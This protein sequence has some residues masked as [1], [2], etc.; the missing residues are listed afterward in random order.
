MGFIDFLLGTTPEKP[1]VEAKASMAI[2]YYQDTFSAFQFFGINRNDA[3]QV[4]AVARARNIIAGTIAELGLESYNKTTGAKVQG[5]SLLRQPDPALPR[6]VTMCWTV[7][8]ILFKGHAFWLVLAIDAQTGAATQARRID[9]TRVTFTTDLETDEIVNGFYLDGNLLPFTGVGSLIMFSGI[10]EGLLNRGGRTI[11]TALKLEEAVQRM[12]TEPNPT[13]VIKN[14]GVDLPPEQVSS[15]LAQWKQARATRSTAYL[16]GPLDVTTFGYDAGQM[17]LSESRLNTA[18]EIARLCNIPAWYLNAESA[19][20]TYSSVTQERRSLID[21]SLKPYMACISERLSMP[22]LCPVN[23][24]VKFDL[25]DYLRGNPLEQIE[26]L[27][28]MLAAGLIDVAEAREE[29]DLAP[30]GNEAGVAD[31]ATARELNVAEVVQKV[32]LGVDKVITSDEAR[33]IV[34]AAG[35]NLQVPGPDFT[36]TNTESDTNAT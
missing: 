34:N 7:E 35:G 30:R 6:I 9:P 25:D 4:P 31:T 18:A 13:M 19:S 20:A 33:E 29:M 16:S 23:Q 5:N 12:A 24:I 1:Q 28:R 14:T 26:V 22:D 32:Y 8:D 2:P 11:S 21:F 17:Q 10:D 27:E 36:S 3:M 15:L